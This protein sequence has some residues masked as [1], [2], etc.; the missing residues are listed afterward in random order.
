MRKYALIAVFYLALG[1]AGAFAAPCTIANMNFGGIPQGTFETEG[2]GSTGTLDGFFTDS[3]YECTASG[4]TILTKP[5]NTSLISNAVIPFYLSL[6]DAA[7]VT[8]S[9]LAETPDA[10]DTF[11]LI[12]DGKTIATDVASGADTKATIM[13][14]LNT[15]AITENYVGVAATVD[16][17]DPTDTLSV[18]VSLRNLIT[19][20][21]TP[22]P[23]TLSLLGFGAACLVGLRRRRRPT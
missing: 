21:S 4:G 11:D 15:L 12:L 19:P 13:A 18:G 2:A 5:E 20:V 7:N 10:R 16:A 1:S 9:V 8:I 6:T 3:Y 17:V 23:A 22:E 14:G